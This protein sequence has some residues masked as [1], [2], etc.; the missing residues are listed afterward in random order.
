MSAKTYALFW[1]L[2][3]GVACS[4]YAQ[5]NKVERQ[6]QLEPAIKT[7]EEADKTKPPAEGAVL[8]IGSSSIT[9]W[10]SLRE[11]FPKARVINRGFG[12]SHVEDSIDFADRIIFR[13]RPRLIVLYAGDNDIHQIN[14]N[15]R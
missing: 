1:S 3:L 10:T 12:G 7:F 5:S 6:R 2:L 11:D 14:N 9:L 8:F 4:T 13:C 15:S